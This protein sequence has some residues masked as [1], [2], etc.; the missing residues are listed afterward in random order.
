MLKE[1][2]IIIAGDDYLSTKIMLTEE[3]INIFNKIISSM[4]P[5]GKFVPSI[6]IRDIEEEKK[7]LEEERKRI[8]KE[9]E[10]RRESYRNDSRNFPSA[11]SLAFQKAMN[12]N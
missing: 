7:Y 12:K 6:L 5:D 10:D 11:M 1:Y 9:R 8:K 3:E 2:E 4:K